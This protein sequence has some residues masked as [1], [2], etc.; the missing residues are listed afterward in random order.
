MNPLSVR[1]AVMTLE[2]QEVS[3]KH[4]GKKSSDCITV[5][6]KTTDC[7]SQPDKERGISLSIVEGNKVLFHRIHS[8]A[9]IWYNVGGRFVL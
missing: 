1:N 8:G 2:R 5:V 9:L 3:V 6:A 7:S 4:E